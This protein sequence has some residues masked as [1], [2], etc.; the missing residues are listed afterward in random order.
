V[1]G[2]DVGAIVARLEAAILAGDYARA[3]SEYDSLPDPAKQA[4]AE[5]IA[6]VKARQTADELAERALSGA[7]RTQEG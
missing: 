7:L 2:D 6:R 5:F 4:G 1:E 3:A